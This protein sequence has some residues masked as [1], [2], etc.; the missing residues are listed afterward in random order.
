VDTHYYQRKNKK[1]F[2]QFLGLG[3][4]FLALFLILGWN[5]YP[6]LLLIWQ[7]FLGRLQASCGCTHHLSFANHPFIFSSLI[8]AGIGILTLLFFLITILIKTN[9]ATKQFIAMSLKNKKLVLSP[10]LKR[11]AQSV[12]LENKIIE[13]KTRGSF[14][15]CF[16][17]F[18]PKI[19]IS[20][21]L[22]QKLSTSELTAVLLH[23]Q[24]HLSVYDPIKLFFIKIL[25]KILFFIPGLKSLSKQYSILSELAADEYATNG[26]RNK[27][28]LIQ[29]L[30][31]VMGWQKQLIL[32]NKLAV[33]FFG[34]VLDE[35]INKLADNDYSPQIK[36]FT[37]KLILNIAF[38][39][40]FFFV[41]NV[42]L[43]SKSSVLTSPANFSCSSG[44][45]QINQCNMGEGNICKMANRSDK[46]SC[47]GME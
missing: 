10:K 7:S 8:F 33:P 24:Y 25:N 45:P 39:F 27:I 17:F 11:V 15:F 34:A 23:E 47:Q 29:A 31:K 1:I 38:I 19:C 22:I 32:Q 9:K 14:I 40:L 46:H 16:N 13:T 44:Q 20:T 26:F 5:L 2:Y 41:F 30:Y 4:T 6:K 28:P 36:T 43:H 35:R 37:P 18:R 12:N 3:F 21:A 42:I